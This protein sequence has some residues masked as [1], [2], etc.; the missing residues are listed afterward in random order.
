M[1]QSV[2]RSLLNFAGRCKASTWIISVIGNRK[3]VLKAFLL[4]QQPDIAELRPPKIIQQRPEID[5]EIFRRLVGGLEPVNIAQDLNLPP[6]RCYQIED[7]LAEH[8]PRVWNRIRA[9][10]QR[11]SPHLNFDDHADLPRSGPDPA[12]LLDQQFERRQLESA[13]QRGLASLA[14]GE[15]RLLLLLYNHR[16]KI[17][18]IVERARTDPYLGLEPALDTNRAYY[19]KNRALGKILS[20]LVEEMGPDAAPAKNRNLLQS[21]E[22][23]LL[24]WGILPRGGET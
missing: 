3:H 7:L 6:G 9:N 24:E 5:H 21:L 11:L 2:R 15:R 4:H 22:D 20:A 12:N 16:L 19:L 17:S 23:L 8:S 10:R 13:L 18:E 1:A 14:S